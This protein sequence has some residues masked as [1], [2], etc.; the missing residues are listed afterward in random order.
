[1]TVQEIA[2]YQNQ[3]E[4]L[5]QQIAHANELVEKC[6]TLPQETLTYDKKTGKYGKYTK[7][8]HKLLSDRDGLRT[9]LKDLNKDFYIEAYKHLFTTLTK[10]LLFRSEDDKEMQ[11]FGDAVVSVMNKS[12]EVPAAIKE[13]AQGNLEKAEFDILSGSLRT[14]IQTELY[15][16]YYVVTVMKE[17]EQE[18]PSLDEKLD[19]ASRNGQKKDS[20]EISRDG[21]EEVI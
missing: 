12:T 7:A 21:F 18:L 13:M 20:K 16:H 3:K 6:K 10:D 17:P 5:K 14:Q 8:Y 19:A 2:S 9:S 4:D 15:G 1:M 11:M